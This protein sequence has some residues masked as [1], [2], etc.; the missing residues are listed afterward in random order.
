VLPGS[1]LR[2]LIV[3]ACSAAAGCAAP[4]DAPPAFSDER[5]LC[6]PEHA[7]EFEAL[8]EECRALRESSVCAGV[9]SLQGNIDSEDVTLDT[10]LES[11]TFSVYGG[12]PSVSADLWLVAPAPYF[13][14]TLGLLYLAAPPLSSLSGQLPDQCLTLA[15]PVT[16]TCMLVNVEA[17]GGNYLSGV[18]N[19]YRTVELETPSEKRISFSADLVRGGHI[20]ACLHAFVAAPPQD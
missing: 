13:S 20:D 10:R 17:R 5:Y 6:G 7:A 1:R 15:R 9:L 3:A 19:M 16:A 12:D 2:A 4:L 14:I 18:L 11:A 8:V